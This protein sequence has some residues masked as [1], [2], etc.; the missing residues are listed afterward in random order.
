M[1]QKFKGIFTALLT[2]F[3]E[4]DNVNTDA[5]KKLVEYNVKMGVQGFYVGGST[6]EA[7]LRSAS[8]VLIR[9][10]NRIQH[11]NV[12]RVS[13]CEKKNYFTCFS[14]H[15]GFRDYAFA[16]ILWWRAKKLGLRGDTRGYNQNQELWYNKA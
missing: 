3:D 10:F 2:P 4:N 13:A 1:Y 15:Y 7:F 8:S 9:Y 12:R 16:F 6:A 14:I 5:L 11:Y